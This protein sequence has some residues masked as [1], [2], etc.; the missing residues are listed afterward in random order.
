MQEI[1]N[2]FNDFNRRWDLFLNIAKFEAD[3]DNGNG[4]KTTLIEITNDCN[5]YE[6]DDSSRD[7]PILAH[8]HELCFVL[9]HKHEYVWFCHISM[10][11]LSSGT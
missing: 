9:S 7:L 6:C 8:K 2:I 10:N 11:M 5:E 1:Y 3:S 4:D